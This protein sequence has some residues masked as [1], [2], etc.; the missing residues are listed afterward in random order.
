M[1]RPQPDLGEL[2]RADFIQ[3]VGGA[4]K[5]K[6]LWG[7]T[8]VGE[9]EV[10]PIRRYY[11]P[12]TS[13]P[14]N[15]E[16]LFKYLGIYNDIE[17]SS[18]PEG[19]TNAFVYLN[20]NKGSE[21]PAA[22][23]AELE[24]NYK[25]FVASNL[26]TMW[27]DYADGPL[28]EG[29]TLTT[30]IVIEADINA[31]TGAGR[32]FIPTTTT[33]LNPYWSLPTLISAIQNNYETLWDT[34]LI[35]QQ[36]VGVI[37]KGSITDPVTKITT[38]D[39]DDLTPN[40]PWLATIARYALKDGTI[41]TNIK[42]VEIGIGTTT[43]G[44][45]Y[46]TYVVTLELP[47][48][49][50]ASSSSIVQSI[51]DDLLKDHSA[52]TYSANTPKFS[53]P[54]S[55]YTSQ[56]IRAMDASDLETDPDLVTRT[57]RLFEDEAEELNT[58]YSNL[59]YYY[60]GFYYLKADV[61]SNPRAYNLTF[62]ELNSYIVRLIDTGY[63]KK[64]VKWWKK[65]LAVIVFVVAVVVSLGNAALTA[66]ALATA[67]VTASLVLVLFSLAFS[68][69]GMEGMAAAFMEVNK[70]IE[71]LVMIASLFL[72]VNSLS[73][74]LQ[75]SLEQGL[76]EA[77]K[78]RVTDFVEKIIE[79]ALDLVSGNLTESS[80]SFLDKMV[81][82][83]ML[84][85]QLKLESLNDRNRDL[86]AEWEQLSQEL[87]RENDILMH[88]ARVYARPATAD[89][90][91]YTEQFDLP[92]ERGGGTLA[93]GNIQRTTKQALRKADYSDSAFDNILI[94]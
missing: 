42:D 39:E 59:W 63:T 86:K 23:A 79:G 56:A 45:V 72:L 32:D 11:Y 12:D 19:V 60:L 48:T 73:K 41:A 44:R 92:Y 74:A 14:S 33:V 46:H 40:D 37:N 54:N 83:F 89:W 34:S 85:Q 47:Y 70:T 36:G 1:K 77:V 81:N 80:L 10:L 68:A 90:S 58:D 22:D 82:L 2:L 13:R 5:F 26:N 25:D 69:L 27:W 21:L 38:P 43:E 24:S 84:P 51:V 50:F 30:S 28:P 35:S 94:I 65:A 91:I 67:I 87:S 55:Y 52:L 49:Q 57:Y 66:Q 8:T 61:F 88:F 78:E 17:N 93:M 4:R 29:L 15:Y 53:F 18:D 62:K 64:K 6:R 20:K 9:V 7:T 71:P 76:Q 3:N 16:K 31:G 75:K